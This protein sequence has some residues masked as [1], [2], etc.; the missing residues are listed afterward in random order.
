MQ[1]GFGIHICELVTKFVRRQ[2]CSLFVVLTGL[3]SRYAIA[4]ALC[5]CKLLFINVN[6]N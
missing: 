2:A 1:K 5:F 4:S 6:Y 3:P